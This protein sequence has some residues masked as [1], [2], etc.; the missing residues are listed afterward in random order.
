MSKKLW[1]FFSR[2]LK[3]PLHLN[4]ELTHVALSYVS[5]LFHVLHYFPNLKL[6]FLH[7]VMFKHPY[8]TYVNFYLEIFSA[9]NSTHH[10]LYIYCLDFYLKK[11]IS[12]SSFEKI[13]WNNKFLK[14]PTCWNYRGGGFEIKHW[15]PGL[16]G[17]HVA[18]SC[19]VSKTS[20]T[21]GSRQLHCGWQPLRQFDQFAVS[22]LL[23][24][25]ISNWLLQNTLLP[26]CKWLKPFQRNQCRIPKTFI[27]EI[28]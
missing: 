11:I 15:F 28:S 12:P 24:F 18:H 25:V 14:V 20:Q 9:M 4:L 19:G 5:P 6:S 22:T 1:H 21:R 26:K 16:I 7:Q 17:S 3:L 13:L 8:L 10:F 27:E 23:A 2:Y